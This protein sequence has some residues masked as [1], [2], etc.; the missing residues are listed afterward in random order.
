MAVGVALAAWSILVLTEARFFSSVGPPPSASTT[1]T[2]R[3]LPGEDGTPVSLSRTAPAHRWLERGTWLGRLEAPAVK[4]SATIVEG[5][6][7]GTLAHAAG[8]IEDTALPGERGNVGIAGHRDTTFRPVRNLKVGD[9]LVLT[10]A[11]RVYEY[12]VDSLTIVDPDA[13]YVLDPTDHPTL[14]LVTCYPFTFIG[15][16]PRRYIV[17]ADLVGAK[18]R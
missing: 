3:T 2:S 15:H 11:N 17:K 13:V 5:S 16:A 4:L 18:N 10:T 14:T 9:T 1:R 7:D 6:D 12:K 8:H